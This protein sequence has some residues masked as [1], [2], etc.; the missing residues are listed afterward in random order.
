[1]TENTFSGEIGSLKDLAINIIYF[2]PF[3]H[4]F[5]HEQKTPGLI[6]VHC[7]E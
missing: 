1:M 7:F 5:K 6:F 4:F 3:F 2:L